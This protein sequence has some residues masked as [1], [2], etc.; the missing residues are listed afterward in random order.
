MSSALR[1]CAPA[2]PPLMTVEA[3]YALTHLLEPAT[4]GQG[5]VA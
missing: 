5:D 3:F 2:P 4:D 1:A